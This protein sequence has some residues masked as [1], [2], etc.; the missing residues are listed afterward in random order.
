MGDAGALIAR[1]IKSAQV[2]AFEDLGCESIKRMTIE[3]LP[4]T[5]AIDSTGGNLYTAGQAAWAR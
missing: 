1:C 2:I 5:V 4:L 3:D